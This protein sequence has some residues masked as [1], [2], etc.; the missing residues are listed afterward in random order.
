MP[1]FLLQSW[2]TEGIIRAKK[3]LVNK[4][5]PTPFLILRSADKK[6]G[7]LSRLFRGALS[8]QPPPEIEMTTVKVF[9]GT[10]GS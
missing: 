3:P 4:R 10:T 9:P 8:I 7:H 6:S 5:Y 1:D 2:L